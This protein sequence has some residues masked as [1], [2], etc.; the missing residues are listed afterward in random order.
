MS[1]FIANTSYACNPASKLFVLGRDL[2]CIVL[3]SQSK[4][5]AD[6]VV[7]NIAVIRRDWYKLRRKMLF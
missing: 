6:A 4:Q 5:K 7:L 1:T 3:V 2:D